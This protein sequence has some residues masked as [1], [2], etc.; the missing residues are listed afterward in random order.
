[1]EYVYRVLIEW[2]FNYTVLIIVH[3]MLQAVLRVVVHTL[4]QKMQVLEE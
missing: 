4:Q 2:C 1:M 3:L